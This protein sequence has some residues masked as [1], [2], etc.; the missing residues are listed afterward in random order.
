MANL[1][2]QPQSRREDLTQISSD[3]V[4]TQ[5][6]MASFIKDRKVDLNLCL[7]E[8]YRRAEKIGCTDF[9]CSLE[10]FRA[11]ATE[12]GN[13]SSSTAREAIS[14][15]QGEMLGFYKDASRENY[16]EDI[17]GPDF[18]VTGLGKFENIT[19]VEIKNPVGSAIK[20][21]NGPQIVPIWSFL[22][23]IKYIIYYG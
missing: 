21:A 23:I 12:N 8:V 15:L 14:I 16:G 18:L 10:R 1:Y 9:E 6:Q 13:L 7:D 11:L 5:T 19:H 4:P 17:N 2:E 20:I 3:V 22:I